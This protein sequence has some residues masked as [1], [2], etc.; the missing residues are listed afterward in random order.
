MSSLGPIVLR[1]LNFNKLSLIN[2]NHSMKRRKWKE[3]RNLKLY[4]TTI[5]EKLQ[6]PIE[7]VT[8]RLQ[9]QG[10]NLLW[11]TNKWVLTLRL[12]LIT[13]SHLQHQNFED[14]QMPKCPIAFSTQ[15]IKNKGY[16]IGKSHMWIF[17]VKLSPTPNP[18]S[19]QQHFRVWMILFPVNCQCTISRDWNAH[20]WQRRPIPNLQQRR[21]RE[22]LRY[23]SIMSNEVWAFPKS[24]STSLTAN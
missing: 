23:F 1:S 21:L 20:W 17:K 9:N 3:F 2:W 16:N 19:R 22:T 15:K 4:S 7:L 24:E 13:N 12:N 6:C 10:Y 18:Q 11:T 5:E 8:K 14:Y